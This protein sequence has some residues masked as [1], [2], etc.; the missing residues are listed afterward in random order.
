MTDVEKVI[1]NSKNQENR[2]LK[3]YFKF[4][5]LPLTVKKIVFGLKHFFN[6]LSGES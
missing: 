5:F 1:K 6:D 3:S 2:L 4:I